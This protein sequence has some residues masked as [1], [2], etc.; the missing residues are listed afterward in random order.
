MVVD[1][2][3]LGLLLRNLDPLYQ[4]ALGENRGVEAN[5]LRCLDFA[6][7]EQDRFNDGGLDEHAAYWHERLAGGMGGVIS[8]RRGSPR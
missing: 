7:F 3:S 4:Q 1:G 8:T 5:P 2:V 6:V